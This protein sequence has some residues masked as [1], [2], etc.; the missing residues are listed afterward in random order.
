MSVD[1][2][3]CPILPLELERRIFE[4]SALSRPTVIPQLIRVAWRVKQ[5]VEPLLY[6]T[7]CIGATS[8]DG[9]PI[10]GLPRCTLANFRGIAR[11]KSAAFLR[12]SIRN[13][14][15]NVHHEDYTVVEAVIALCSGIENLFLYNTL[16]YPL[17]ADLDGLPLR[18]Y[19]GDMRFELETVN[20][21]QAVFTN[22]THL[23]LFNGL[24]VDDVVATSAQYHVLGYLPR[25]THLAFDVLLD[26]PT[27]SILLESCKLLTAL[28]ILLRPP[29]SHTEMDVVATDPRFVMMPLDNYVEDWQRG[30]LTGADFWACADEFIAQR[31]SGEIPGTTFLLEE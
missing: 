22:I 31:K 4:I 23:E 12:D 3:P 1:S 9:F 14:M 29:L 30:V 7:L 5:W 13:V 2:V 26:L 16:G 20:G 27:Y 24:Y 28:L 15:V 17:A 19:Y 8:I 6:R 21:A 10:N 25:L 11:T 18:H